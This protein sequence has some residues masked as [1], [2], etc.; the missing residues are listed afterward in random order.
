MQIT[1]IITF[2]VTDKTQ[3]KNV[4]QKLYYLITMNRK[5]TFKIREL[6]I[7]KTKCDDNL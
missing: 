4:H 3:I 5:N 6:Q 1:K 2:V 7:C